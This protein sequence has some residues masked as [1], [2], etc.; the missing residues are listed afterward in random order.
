[1]IC[2]E[3]LGLRITL[4]ADFVFRGLPTHNW[5][6]W[7]KVVKSLQ[8]R[9]SRTLSFTPRGVLQPHPSAQVPPQPAA[10]HR[11]TAPGGR[12]VNWGGR[13]S[14][15]TA[16]S[17]WLSPPAVK[18]MSVS[19]LEVGMGAVGG[20]QGRTGQVAP[21]YSHFQRGELWESQVGE[22]S[23]QWNLKKQPRQQE[24]EKEALGNRKGRRGRRIC[25]FSNMMSW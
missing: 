20:N 5:R 1:M 13:G 12:K 17:G 6:P 7:S 10:R 3:D 25:T 2:G 8:A 22:V 15:P 24:G 11:H 18:G 16:G 9:G 21:H 4:N 23:E 14:I 19:V